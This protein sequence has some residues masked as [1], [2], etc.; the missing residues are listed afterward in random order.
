MAFLEILELIYMSPLRARQ[1]TTLPLA[2]K[3][4]YNPSGA[5][6]SCSTP[7]HRTTMRRCRSRPPDAGPAIPPRVRRHRSFS[8][9]TDPVPTRRASGLGLVAQP[10]N[11]T[12]F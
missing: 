8:V 11:L 6:R 1:N 5:N 12:V 2:L 9:R 10:S 7:L 4:L 3:L